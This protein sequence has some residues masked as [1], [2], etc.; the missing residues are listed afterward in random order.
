MTNKMLNANSVMVAKALTPMFEKLAETGVMRFMK[1][2]TKIP[3]N[4]LF[5]TSH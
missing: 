2:V 1:F 4:E 3:Y 5:P